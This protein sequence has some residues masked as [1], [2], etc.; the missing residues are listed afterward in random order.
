MQ[1]H[2]T[3]YG[4]T[5]DKTTALGIVEIEGNKF[6]KI[7]KTVF[8]TAVT[9]MAASTIAEARKNTLDYTCHQARAIVQDHGSI[10][11][12]TGRYTFDRFVANRSYCPMGDYV[13]RAK[14]PTRDRRYCNIGFVCTMDNPYDFK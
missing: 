13:K 2:L 5:V 4:H 9:F 3:S 8:A 14:A 10:L 12:S 6:M 1:K 11:M 7:W